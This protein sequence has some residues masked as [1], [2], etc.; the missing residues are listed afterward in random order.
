MATT[1]HWALLLFTDN[2]FGIVLLTLSP[3]IP[4][5]WQATEVTRKKKMI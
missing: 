5:I 4:C 1:P 2:K 3:H